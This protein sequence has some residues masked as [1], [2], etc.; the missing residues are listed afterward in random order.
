MPH[1]ETEPDSLLHTPYI[2]FT[3]RGEKINHPLSKADPPS[4]QLI[5]SCSIK[6]MTDEIVFRRQALE[7]QFIG[8]AFNM[9]FQ[10]AQQI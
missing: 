10:C 3:K 7:Y 8:R 5:R 1:K 4:K 9:V 2:E 6:I